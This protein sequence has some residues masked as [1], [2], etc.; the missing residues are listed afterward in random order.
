ML[1]AWDDW[2]VDHIAK[3]GV[4]PSEAEYVVKH[5]A[6]PFPREH[7][8]DK[9]VVWGQTADGGYLQVIFVFRSEDEVDVDSLELADLVELS[10]RGS[11]V[12]VYVIHA[13]SLTPQ[14]LMQ[15]RRLRR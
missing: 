8:D 11:P 7:G 15:Y 10:N 3:H 4:T 5:A 9:F 12:V 14:M 2:N 6:A 13:M 1:F